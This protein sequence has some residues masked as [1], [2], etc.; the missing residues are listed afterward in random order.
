MSTK[1]SYIKINE[2]KRKIYLNKSGGPVLPVNWSETKK[3]NFRD[4]DGKLIRIYITDQPFIY[5]TTWYNK[6]ISLQNAYVFYKFF[7]CKE[8]RLTMG[9]AIRDNPNIVLNFRNYRTIN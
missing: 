8:F 7:P 2:I 3:Q 9:K 6:S 5:K 4:K 1:T